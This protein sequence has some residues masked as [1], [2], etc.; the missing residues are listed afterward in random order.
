VV[1]WT[2]LN[3]TL[4]VHCLSCV[5]CVLRRKRPLRRADHSFRG[6]FRVC[7]SY[8][9]SFRN[10]NNWAAY[11]DHHNDINNMANM[12]KN[13]NVQYND[14]QASG[15]LNTR[16]FTYDRDDSCVNK[17]Q[18]VPVIHEPPCIWKEERTQ[19]SI[20]CFPGIHLQFKYAVFWMPDKFTGIWNHVYGAV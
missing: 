5:C 18:F 14:I 2:H 19:N 6:V 1:P 9:V 3:V 10:L 17:S 8:C 15:L 13:H 7:L 16:W 12:N 4:Y 20:R 11:P